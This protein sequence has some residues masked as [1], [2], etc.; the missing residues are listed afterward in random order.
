MAGSVVPTAVASAIILRASSSSILVLK[1]YGAD[2]P[3]RQ[4]RPARSARG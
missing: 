3:D 4:L 1:E 2:E